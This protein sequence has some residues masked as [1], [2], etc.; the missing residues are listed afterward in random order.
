MLKRWL[1]FSSTVSLVV[2]FV[3]GCGTSVSVTLLSNQ[4]CVSAILRDSLTNLPVKQGW[5]AL[6]SGTPN[7]ALATVSFSRPQVATSDPSGSVQVCAANFSQPAVVIFL[8]LD[9]SGNAYAPLVEQVSKSIDLGAVSIGACIISCGF[10]RQEET[11]APAIIDGEIISSP[12]SNN[13]FVVPQYSTAALDGSTSIWNITI[14]LLSKD[15]TNSF[16]TTVNGCPGQSQ[17][18]TSY[19]MT[20][21]SQN[22]LLPTLTGFR[23]NPG[24]PV[25]SILAQSSTSPSCSPSTIS[26]YFAANGK[27]LT[28]AP[29]SRL[30]AKNILFPQ[31]H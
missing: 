16:T 2:I 23:Q 24:S 15:Q 1:I 10:D 26:T 9:A 4:T 8:A 6:E 21:P 31:C 3:A 13:G 30:F 28:A 19:E 11:S 25:Y 27:P 29:G 12:I 22:P 7:A 5:A 17:F 18:C 14:P 20:L